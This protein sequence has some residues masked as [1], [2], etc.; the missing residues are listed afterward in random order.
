MPSATAK[1]RV[2]IVEDSDDTRE[3]FQEFLE[4]VGHEVCG[5]AT[6][7]EGLEKLES[8]LPDIS[9]IDVGLPDLDGYEL[10]RRARTLAHGAKTVLVALTGYGGAEAKARSLEAGF[11]VHLTKP[12]NI[13]DLSSLVDSAN[14]RMRPT[15]R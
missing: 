1:R 2:L 11:D 7:T 10:A 12:V 3:T 13:S 4:D 15:S 6:A 14:G 8:F 9:F 5:A